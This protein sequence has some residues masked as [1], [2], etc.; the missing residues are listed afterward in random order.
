[1]KF[2]FLTFVLFITLSTFVVGQNNLKTAFTKGK[3]ELVKGKE[4]GNYVF[5]LPEETTSESVEQNAE[6]YTLYFTVN[7]NENTREATINMKTNDEK[8]R[9]IICRFLV[10][11]EV[12]FVNV[13]G[14]NHT[15][16]E[17]YQVYLKD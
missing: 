2:S 6:Y 1:M 8:S 5:V 3:N 10:S 9:H 11:S 13:N 4:S 15:V 14:K 7:F 16:E 12:E 17:F